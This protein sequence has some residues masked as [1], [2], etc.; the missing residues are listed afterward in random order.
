MTENDGRA[1]RQTIFY[2]YMHASIYGRG[3]VLN[4]L[5]DSPK[6]DS[7]DYTDVP[8][9]DSVAVVNE[10]KD[11]ITIFAVNKDM[12]ETLNIHCDLRGFGECKLIE[13]IIFQ[14]DD[15][16]I[17]NSKDHPFR[18]VPQFKNDAV[19][20]ERYLNALLPK[21]SWNVIRLSIKK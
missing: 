13:H 12:K 5:V 19:V 18:I 8:V 21:L 9:L 6:Y 17:T 14:N 15:V 16:K 11:E 10:E 20:K 7:K 2:P 1:W 4:P 3:Y